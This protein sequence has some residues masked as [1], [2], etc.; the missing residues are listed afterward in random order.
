M[1]FHILLKVRHVDGIK[2]FAQ[3]SHL[4]NQRHVLF[5]FVVGAFSQLL[6]ERFDVRL[7]FV[8]VRKS[9]RSLFEH[10][11]SVLRHEVL[12]QV[13]NYC[14]LRCRHLSACSRSHPSQ[15]FQQGAFARTVFTHQGDAVLFVDNK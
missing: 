12:R 11:S 3:R 13:G 7:H 8:Q 9:L 6:V 14:V 1:F 2:L 15:N 4:L 5:A 10:G